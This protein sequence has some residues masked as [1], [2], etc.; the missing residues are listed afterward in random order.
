M[1]RAQGAGAFSARA[2]AKTDFDGSLELR[3]A[4]P[5][6]RPQC[7]HRRPPF[8]HDLDRGRRYGT[9]EDFQNFVKLAYMCPCMHHSGGTV[10]EPVDLPVNKRH[11]EMVYAHMRYSDKPYI[12]SVTAPERAEDMVAMSEILFGGEFV[13]AKYRRDEPYQRQFT[14]GVGRDDARRRRDLCSQQ[15]SPHHHSDH[16]VRRHE[17]GQRR[18]KT[19]VL[20]ELCPA[21]HSCSWCDAARP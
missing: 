12:G 19:Q 8:V 1:Q 5:Q 4:R 20:A 21:P 7:S 11:L 9:M 14:D 17:P 15:S 3:P 16:P 2:G 13:Q 6:P 18:W 10:C